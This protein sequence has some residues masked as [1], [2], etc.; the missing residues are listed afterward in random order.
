MLQK[1]IRELTGLIE[2]TEDWEA[3]AKVICDFACA[4]SDAMLERAGRPWPDDSVDPVKHDDM[5][6]AAGE[7][8]LAE[9]PGDDVLGGEDPPGYFKELR[10]FDPSPQLHHHLLGNQSATWKP[11]LFAE[12]H[13][14]EYDSNGKGEYR[15]TRTMSYEEFARFVVLHMMRKLVQIMYRQRWDHVAQL[16]SLFDRLATLTTEL[17]EPE[18]LRY[19]LVL[20]NMRPNDDHIA[21]MLS[22]ELSRGVQVK[23]WVVECNIDRQDLTPKRSGP[24]QNTMIVMVTYTEL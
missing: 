23:E 14:A 24:R 7:N 8:Q 9:V 12:G 5:I 2:T 22:E 6:T 20:H 21:A 16:P 15:P 13:V 11:Y 10:L 1:A 19:R 3:K 4:V 18:E 17:N